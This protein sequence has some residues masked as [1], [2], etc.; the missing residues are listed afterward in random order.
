MKN[1]YAEY[2]KNVSDLSANETAKLNKQD[3]YGGIDGY[4]SSP[5][6]ALIAMTNQDRVITARAVIDE[7]A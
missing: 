7:I 5:S 2:N 3:E 6:N 1:Y 4:L